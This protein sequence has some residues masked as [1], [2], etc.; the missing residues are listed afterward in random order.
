M[1]RG[2]HCLKA[3]VPGQPHLLAYPKEVLH[4]PRGVVL[5]PRGQLP[6]IALEG[7]CRSLI[8]ELSGFLNA[9]NTAE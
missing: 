5:K 9:E 6:R 2:H 7:C 8:Q 3:R 1:E 4:V